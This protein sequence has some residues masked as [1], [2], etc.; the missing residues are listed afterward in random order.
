MRLKKLYLIKIFKSEG[1]TSMIQSNYYITLET[2][3]D[4]KL[5]HLSF[6]FHKLQ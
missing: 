3:I 1:I 5:L 2:L 4:N 6:L